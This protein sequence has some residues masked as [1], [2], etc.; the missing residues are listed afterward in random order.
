MSLELTHSSSI[1][2]KW[3]IILTI[4]TVAILEVLDSTIV[5]VAL[6]TMMPSLGADQEQITWVLT[7]YIVASAIMMP[8]TGFLSERMG[9]KKLLLINISGFMLSSFLCGLSQSLTQ[10]ILFRLLQGAFGAAL[11]PLSQSILRMSFP[12]QQQ[13]KVMAIWGLGIMVA[14]VFGP[15]LG[16]YI[17]EHTTWRW[18]FYL[19]APICFLSLLLTIFVVPKTEPRAKKIDWF[20]IIMMFIGVGSLQLFLDQGNSKDWFN[21]NFITLMFIASLIFITLFLVRCVKHQTPVIKLSLFRDRNFSISSLLMALFAGCV[22][23]TL[24]LEPIMLESLYQYPVV[25]AGMTISPT[26]IA[27]A[28]GM[29]LVSELI[30]RIDVRYI[31]FTG[32]LFAASGAYY[33]ACSTLD[34]SQSHFLIAN[35]LSGFGM[36]IFMVPLA[37]YA[38]ATV[39]RASITEASGLFSYSRMLGTSIAISLSSTLVSREIQ[40]NWNRLGGFLNPFSQNAQ[41]WAQK[42]H[43]ALQAPQTVAQ[44]SQVLYRQAHISAFVDAYLG[45]ALTFALLIP[46]LGLIKKVE[47]P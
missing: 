5:N 17:T 15:T 24:T 23:A 21:S 44:L 42:Q 22:F 47:L 38:L 2:D 35:A 41:W 10:M 40:V 7:S 9:H 37:T 20:G 39:P 30:K 33:L 43:L 46:L 6:P 16:G 14:P 18:L 13:G 25:T 28:C 27:S 31:L 32:L 19:N 12:L 36:G 8:L 29:I 34:V 1:S 3:L 11:V 45:I 26:G 4:M